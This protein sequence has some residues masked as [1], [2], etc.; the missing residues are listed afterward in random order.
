MK[1]TILRL[2]CIILIAAIALPYTITAADTGPSLEYPRRYLSAGM[3]AEL[4]Q[5]VD[6]ASFR[7]ALV[8]EFAEFKTSVD[9]SSFGI[10]ASMAD[11]VKAF[12]WRD[13]PESFQVY[14]LGTAD[15]GS[16]LTSVYVSYN[17]DAETY[18][19]MLDECGRAAGFLVSGIAGNDELDDVQKALLIHDRLCFVCEYDYT[20]GQDCPESYTMYGAIVNGSAVCDGYAKA[21]SYLLRLA[22]VKSYS[23]VSE[24][25]NHA[26]N[27]VCIDGVYYH[28]DVTWD[29]QAWWTFERGK[30][31]GM[32]HTNFLRS[33]TG[34]KETG[35]TASDFTEPENNTKY[36]SYFWQGSEAAFC[37]L[38]G[39]IYWIDKESKAIRTYS[40][41]EVVTLEGTW[42]AKEQ[43]YYWPG[44]Y[45]RICEARGALYY[46]LPD[47]VYAYDPASGAS[48]V[49]YTPELE[50][51]MAIYGIEVRGD[52]LV[53][54]VN[55]CP[56]QD[57]S[58][59]Y[60]I[61]IP[62]PPAVA[63]SAE[64]TSTVDLAPSQTVFADITT[65]G[66]IAGYYWG[67]DPDHQN[68]AFTA[69][70]ASSV[71]L[72]V[73]EAG[74]YRF[75]AVSAD[76]SVSDTVS[77]TFCRTVLELNG[78][79]A[80]CDD[81]LMVHEYVFDLPIPE[82]E[83]AR[84]M[85]WSTDPAA[86]FGEIECEISD[87]PALARYYA[88]WLELRTVSGRLT[89]V[90]GADA[91]I[92]VS[93]GETVSVTAATVDGR[94]SFE[95][96]A[97]SVVYVTLSAPGHVSLVYRLAPGQVSLPDT[98]MYLTGDV[99]GDGKINNKDVTAL[100][101]AVTESTPLKP[102]TADVNA[103]GKMNNK[104]VSLLFRHVTDETVKLG[105]PLVRMY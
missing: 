30:A 49:Y 73:S 98:D 78:G 60:Q 87:P 45:S 65:E 48:R 96:P 105:T 72:T 91:E 84:F 59:L 80:E 50:S 20:Y 101:R 86:D 7:A 8:P 37:L 97:D 39:E 19:V 15:N 36:D 26:W 104:D 25:L 100:F 67:T 64:L 31:G 71:E 27:L 46:T 11:R 41:D 52:H 16:V 94:Y 95:I 57:V 6:T 44:N 89:T 14:G 82:K 74:T 93:D 76:G 29:D 32:Y 35:H 54:D 103:D 22:G 21:Y 99:N 34:I 24:T 69:S 2:C 23:C 10:P 33:N 75:T 102:G 58:A 79:A 66:V 51:P 17:Y 47:A 1:N 53:I 40:G 13:I 62:L 9:I 3:S 28:T 85:G 55:N 56:S 61:E 92:T 4:E 43:G 81:I 68:N 63:I 83:G 77:V 42:Y 70:S 38:D 88:I 18:A 90:G 12:I 5:Y